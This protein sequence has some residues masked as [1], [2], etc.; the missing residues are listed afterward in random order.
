[1]SLSGGEQAVSHSLYALLV[2][3][4]RYPDP[5][6]WLRGCVNDV[7]SMKEFLIG[8]GV[9]AG[10]APPNVLTLT[11]DQATREAVIDGF[12]THLSRAGA[13]DIA[14]FHFSGHGSQERTA[15]ELLRLEPDGLNETLVCFDSRSEGGWDLADKDLAVLIREL[16]DRG[17]QVTVILDCCHS[18]SGTR[19]PLEPVTSRHAPVHPRTRPI[20]SYLF[21]G[22]HIEPLASLRKGDPPAS[23]WEMWRGGGRHVL[24]AACGDN[25]TAKEY[26]SDGRQHG[27]F[28]FHLLDTLRRS[29]PGLTYR[30]L[31]RRTSALIRASIAQQTPQAEAVRHKDLDRVF[32]DGTIRP[33]PRHYTV[34]YD[35]S[36]GWTVNAGEVHGIR[37]GS[38][39][40]ITVLALFAF[41]D[42][43]DRLHDLSS[44]LGRARVERVYPHLS[45]IRFEGGLEGGQDLVFKAVVIQV[46]LV[47]LAVA[48]QGD[49]SGLALVRQAMKIAGP[50]GSYS[51]VVRE[52]E[53]GKPAR[54][55]LTAQ[56]DNFVITRENNDRP[57]V[58]PLG[59]YDPRSAAIAVRR[60]EHI[61]RWETTFHDLRNE[62][63][64]LGPD[65]V[66]MSVLV[67]GKPVEGTSLQLT[68]E[69]KPDGSWE[70]PSFRVRLV[71]KGQRTLC[72]ALLALAED[73]SITAQ[74]LPA[75]GVF[76]KPGQEAWALEGSPIFA[77]VPKD[78]WSRGVT[79]FSDLL[80]LI[81]S[82]QPFD[83]IALEQ[84]ALD[85]H[86]QP[87][88]ASS[89]PRSILDRLAARVG[90]RVLSARPEESES[91]DDWITNEFA[92]T[93]VRPM[94]FTLVP[95]AG[96]PATLAAGVQI[97]PHSHLRAKA[98]LATI[99]QVARD[100][101]NCELPA[102][103]KES[104]EG[105]QPLT[106]TRA[107]GND[108]GLQ[109]LELS[110][111]EGFEAVTPET[112]LALR[113]PGVLHDGDQVLPV[114]YDG[115]L[116]LPL[117]FA[118][119]LDA[120]TLQVTLERLPHPI[121][122]RERSVHGSVRI[123]FQK[124][125]HQPLGV[126][127]PYP[128]LS[129]ARPDR[130]GGVVYEHDL[131]QVKALVSD[132]N[133]ILLL[134][135]GIFGDTSGMASSVLNRPAAGSGKT[136]VEVGAYDLV[137]TFDYENLNTPIERVAADLKGRLAAVGLAP[138]HA[139][140]LQIVAH[141]MGGLV[142]RWLIEREGGHLI[143]ERLLMLGT[144]NGGSPWPTV[145]SWAT[146]LLGLG[147]N[148]LTPIWWPAAVL[149]QLVRLLKPMT[150]NL[151]QMRPD[152]EF[153]RT[154]SESPDPGIPYAIIA[155]S[156]SLLPRP[157]ETERARADRLFHLLLPDQLAYM[158]A[159]TLFREQE[160][161]LAVSV[162]SMRTLPAGRKYEPVVQ[163]IGCDHLTYF[164]SGPGLNVLGNVVSS[165]RD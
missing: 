114:G 89:A 39:E 64:R 116:F 93:T 164:D 98:R 41:D 103:L 158:A 120:E 141:S 24:L 67:E 80:K 146:G 68:Y 40:D 42:P 86:W 96:A 74:L 127:Y 56:S 9:V 109:V 7:E 118:K 19:G 111:V 52:A 104:P 143:V 155:G 138:G 102:V 144:P 23:G 154:L 157:S 77:A 6:L 151:S 53:R 135:H 79:E 81:V 45:T 28:T 163:L 88:S 128:L 16:A 8:R 50:G 38:G 31:I 131:S 99:T 137:L 162:D 82:T 87:R 110:D 18:G 71:N 130:S 121:T 72:C 124:L 66:E 122:Q 1:M 153:L 115:D 112:P 46:P 20:E 129:A 132:A 152:A 37:A 160:N 90:T 47:P 17:S 63:G 36:Y 101:G 161:D 49:E 119:T 54:L 12:R 21:S 145:Q 142:A 35:P 73:F 2:G 84:D 26:T 147:L 105:S 27:A 165:K 69:L 92:I 159:S 11:N 48:M 70:Q 134:I 150:T 108:P 136:L 62:N 55:R 51:T 29:G 34:R 22:G 13:G 100:L 123:L 83:A 140:Q 139:K 61:A 149:A 126:G 75:G 76:L 10:N 125:V 32:L 156:T 107:R 44:S 94:L 97:E 106:F 43:L 59:P 25:E 91:Y 148:A 133:R 14:L 95:N 57:L 33:A 65:E 85:R 4:D 117:G 30:D 3:I 60:L 113:I 15:K 5:K 58:P 78:W